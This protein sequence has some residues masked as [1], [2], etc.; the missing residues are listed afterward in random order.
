MGS[1]RNYARAAGAAAVMSAGVVVSVL[2]ASTPAEAQLRSDFTITPSDPAAGESFTVSGET[3]IF[4]GAG[5]PNQGEPV[6]LPGTATVLLY[7]FEPEIEGLVFPPGA[8]DSRNALADSEG[9]WSVQLTVPAD[10]EPEDQFFIAVI[11]GGASV[12]NTVGSFGV[13]LPPTPGPTPSSPPQAP[14]GAAPGA[15][16]SE[17]AD[18]PAATPPAAPSAPPATPVDGEPSFVG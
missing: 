6:D 4:E 5:D 1:R 14:P 2:F 16:P 17:P 9:A 18:A 7:D 3:C 10:A 15:T 13:G 8:L 11:C 12:A